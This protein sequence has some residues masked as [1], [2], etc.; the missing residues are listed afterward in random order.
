[1]RQPCAET[2]PAVVNIYSVGEV[3]GSFYSR[4]PSTVFRLGSG[5]IMDD[6]GHILTAAHVVANVSEIDVAPQDGRQYSG[7]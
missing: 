5:V 6:Q 3:Q 4:R 1:M 2:A 7:Q